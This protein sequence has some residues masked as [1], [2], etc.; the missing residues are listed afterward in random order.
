MVGMLFI[1]AE[2]LHWDWD[3]VRQVQV[4][5]F[6]T[7]GWT[8]TIYRISFCTPGSFLLR[9]SEVFTLKFNLEDLQS[10]FGLLE[11]LIRV[12]EVMCEAVALV[13]RKNR[14]SSF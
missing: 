5:G 1:L 10:V 8:L 3:L 11:T 9:K 13:L 2:R 4:F 14:R 6:I 7:S 12:K